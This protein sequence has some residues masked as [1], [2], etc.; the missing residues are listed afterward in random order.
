MT[1][2]CPRCGSRDVVEL[3]GIGSGTG[4]SQE[5][6]MK[7]PDTN[8]HQYQCNKCDNTFHASLKIIGRD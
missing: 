3:Q 4:V 5:P 6:E 1:P 2:K 8:G 7:L